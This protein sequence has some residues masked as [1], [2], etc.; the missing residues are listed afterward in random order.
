MLS[1]YAFAFFVPPLWLCH[2]RS[3]VPPPHAELLCASQHKYNFRS[4]FKSCNAKQPSIHQNHAAR[5]SR[6]LS[7]FSREN[8]RLS[9][10]HSNRI[11]KNSLRGHKL[12]LRVAQ[13][14]NFILGGAHFV[15]ICRSARQ[16]QLWR[17]ESTPLLFPSS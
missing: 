13:V 17:H 9:L 7:S 10:T 4:L 3:P 8:H 2:S 12:T 16:W 1:S 5:H 15:L 6:S 14:P 11:S